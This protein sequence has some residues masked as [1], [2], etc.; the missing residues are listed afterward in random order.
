MPRK[1]RILG[2]AD[3]T[4]E[5]IDE[6]VRKHEQAV[7]DACDAQE[8]FTEDELEQH[9]KELEQGKIEEAEDEA[10]CIL[11]LIE[12]LSHDEQ[13]KTLGKH[14]LHFITVMLAVMCLSGLPGCTQPAPNPNEVLIINHLKSFKQ[15]DIIK[16]DGQPDYKF[17]IQDC[18]DIGY[19]KPSTHAVVYHIDEL[20]MLHENLI[21]LRVCTHAEQ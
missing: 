14:L 6:Q 21:D 9:A 10:R 5:E 17:T 13:V 7:A 20:G 3:M 4:Q 8:Q 15:G 11:S 19:G 16:M 12:G 18:Y 1:H 2:S